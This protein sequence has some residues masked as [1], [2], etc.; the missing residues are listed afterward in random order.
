MV[1]AAD[2]KQSQQAMTETF[3]LSNIAPQVG[4]G[5]NRHCTFH[6]VSPNLVTSLFLTHLETD[7]A[8]LE[9]V[10]PLLVF[11][12]RLPPASCFGTDPSPPPPLNLPQFCRTLTT[13]F[14]DVYV[15]TVP[16]FLPKQERDGKWRVV[17]RFISFR[18]S[19]FKDLS[20]RG[21][22]SANADR[23]NHLTISL[24]TVL[25]DDRSPKLCS[26]KSVP[27]PIPF[28]LSPPS[29][30]YHLE[31]SKTVAVPTH[32]AKVLLTSRP[33]SG[34]GS[35]PEKKEYSMGAFVLPNQV[36]PD[37]TPLTNFVVPGEFFL[38]KKKSYLHSSTGGE[39]FC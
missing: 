23:G 17:S 37:E 19:D 33:S 22:N 25:R 36:I 13:Q 34:F 24:K 7:W 16:L 30:A 6:F 35:S 11:L 21:S 3:L 10:R 15:F 18:I 31:T 5:F 32:F 27:S 8:Y 2:A 39:I 38:F 20:R 12:C 4:E 1:P 28:S 14:E 29:L 26:H 9:Q